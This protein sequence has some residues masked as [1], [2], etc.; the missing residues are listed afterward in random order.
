VTIYNTSGE[1]DQNEFRRIIAGYLKDVTMDNVELLS[2]RMLSN[3]EIYLD[4]RV[5]ATDLDAVRSAQRTFE[6]SRFFNNSK[7]KLKASVIVKDFAAALD[8]QSVLSN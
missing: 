2:R 6:E 4:F 3:N 5:A 8:L 1:L 7:V